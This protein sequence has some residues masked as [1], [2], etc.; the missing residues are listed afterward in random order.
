MTADHR[1]GGYNGIYVQTAGTGD[2]APQAGVASDG[3]FV[4]LTT[5]PAN[6]PGVAIGDQVRVRGTVSEFNGLTEISIGARSRRAGLRA[7]RGAARARPRSPC[8]STPAARESVES[9]LVAPVGDYTVSEVF[10][11]NRFG[12]VVLAAG[13][14]P[15]PIPTD[16]FRPGTQQAQDLAAANK[17]APAAARR[18]L[19]GQPLHRRPAAALPLPRRAAAGRRQRRGV[20]PDRAV[21]RLRRVAPAAG[22]PGHRDH[23]GHRPD[24]VQG[25]PTRAPRRPEAVGGD[26]R[27]ASFNVLNYF[28]HFGGDARGADDEAG[29]AKQEAKIVSAISRAR[30][31]RGGARGDRELGPLRAGRPADG[32]EAAGRRAERQATARARGTTS[33]PPPRCRHPRQQDFITTAIIFK[34]ASVTPA[35]R[36]AHDQRR[37]RVVQRPRAD[38]ADV[39]RGLGHVHRGRQPPQVQEPVGRRDRRQRRHR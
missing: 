4:Y 34:P 39:H 12:E 14:D 25:R 18:R 15:A 26:I 3:V 5:N 2:R 19:V 10:N 22:H 17:L 36:V 37:V 33:A 29:L 31:G 32:A 1:S 13:D 30:R 21:V 20:R 11:T 6:H 24:H 7:R 9:M 8:R 28:V 38:R 35:G 16:R 23:A 27:L